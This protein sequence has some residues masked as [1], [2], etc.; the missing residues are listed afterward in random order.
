MALISFTPLNKKTILLLLFISISAFDIIIPEIIE[1]IIVPFKID[2]FDYL[3]QI[4]IGLPFLLHYLCSK[5]KNYKLFSHFLKL[6]YIIFFIMIIVDLIHATIY[7]IFDD[8]LFFACNLFNRYNIDMILLEIL[9][10]FTSNSGYFFHHFI[11][12]IIF[13]IPSIMVDIYRIYNN[14]EKNIHLNWKH[15][16]IYFLDWIV[17]DTILTYKKYLME[18]KFIPPFIVCFIF[19]LVDLLYLLILF[20]FTLINRNVIC[21]ES[22]CFDIFNFDTDIFKNT[23][24]LIFFI[25]ISIIIDCIFFFL[26]YQ[27]IDLFTTRYVFLSFYIIIM[28]SS[29]K[30]ANDYNL[31]LGG[32]FLIFLAFIF[33]FIGLFIYLEIM[34]LNICNLNENTRIRI[35]ERAR[36]NEME[37]LN[38]KIELSE[39]D[40]E[41]DEYE[42]GKKEEKKIEIVPG[43]LI[44]I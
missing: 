43:Y 20:A 40:E 11:G 7:V 4:I 2:L 12:Q 1:I 26:Y 22:K 44:D 35:A 15:F 8:T 23:F 27:I 21:F 16:V 33:I 25:F 3:S 42:E 18:I 31:N 17:D 41:E 37:K 10:K 30:T 9:S 36:E 13:F 38:S 39:K 29:I 24:N 5:K 14:N 6:D 28:V 34:E 19:G 32:W